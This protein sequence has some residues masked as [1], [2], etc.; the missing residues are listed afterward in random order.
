MDCSECDGLGIFDD[1]TMCT[2]CEGTGEI[3][4]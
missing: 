4:Y 1:S 2:Y 3:D